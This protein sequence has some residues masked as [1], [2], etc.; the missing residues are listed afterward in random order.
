MSEITRRQSLMG[1]AGA[2]AALAAARPSTSAS[3]ATTPMVQTPVVVKP[4]AEKITV[5]APGA[6]KF[7][8]RFDSPAQ[9]A[10]YTRYDYLVANKPLLLGHR[11]GYYP[12]GPW[13]ESAIESA[14]NILATRPCTM[15][16]VDLRMTK[17]GKCVS[18]HDS[19][20]DRETTGAGKL[21]D[22]DSSYVLQQHLVNN[23]G[24]VT[25]FTVRE[26]WEFIKWGV[27]AGAILWLDVK[28]ASPQFVIDMIREYKAESQ[29]IVSAYGMKNLAVY[30]RLAP[31][32]VYFIPTNAGDGL[33]DAR[34][35]A[36]ETDIGRVIGFAGYYVP[37]IDDSVRMQRRYDAPMQIELNRYDE[38]LKSGELDDR[39]YNRVIETR[40]RV[41]C[42][43]HYPRVADILKLTEWAPKP[44][45]RRG[46]KKK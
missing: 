21:I 23:L 5:P 46:G 3:A 2:L 9:L 24:Q 32:L 25:Q 11:A 18:M 44:R 16:E 12:D 4:D 31:E 40:F 30:R 33:P 39:Y 36:H 19:T 15:V 28:D 7:G 22:L 27:E 43:N 6:A 8:I 42:T 20:M 34:A 1:G 26:S 29:V 10:A 17:D 38:G 14:Q 13:P 37:D 35:I 41:I 45:V